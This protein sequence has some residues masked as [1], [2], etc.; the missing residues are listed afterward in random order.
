[1]S[2]VSKQKAEYYILARK[3][4]EQQISDEHP[5][6][7][8]CGRLCTGLHETRCA[9]FKKAVDRRT[10]KILKQTG[11]YAELFESDKD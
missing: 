2:A 8:V 5:L 6:Y 10:D 7:C 4:A 9:K 1:M 11:L 3:K